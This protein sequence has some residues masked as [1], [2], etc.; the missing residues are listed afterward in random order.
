MNIEKETIQ[1]DCCFYS[2]VYITHRPEWINKTNNICDK[3][4][5]DC[6]NRDKQKLKEKQ[7]IYG[8]I[9]D[10]GWSYHSSSLI[11][12][13]GLEEIQSYIG[14]MSYKILN[15]QGFDLTDYNLSFTE[16]WVQ[17]F[18]KKGG[19]HHD[20]HTHYDNH[21]SGFYF[22]KC[23]NKTSY[24]VFH[25]PRAGSI[26]TKL[27][28]KKEEDITLASSKVNYVPKPGTFIFFNS[29]LPHQF[30]VDNGV[31]SFRFIHFNIQAIRKNLQKGIIK[32]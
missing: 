32:I 26:M 19:G 24:P 1:K 28:E 8:K 29:Y 14:K 31:E 27:P 30:V 7:K 20:T 11:N 6:K 17:E 5:L 9:G 22:L 12:C 4:I 15:E 13:L 2:P 3:I 18:G 10:H 25:D 21:I 16:F 23:S